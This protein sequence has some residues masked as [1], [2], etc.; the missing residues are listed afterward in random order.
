MV[1]SHTKRRQQ[2]QST[3]PRGERPDRIERCESEY[4]I[5]I[6]A[7]ARGATR[8]LHSVRCIREDFNPRSREG[9]DVERTEVVRA[10]TISIHAPARGATMTELL[11]SA[12]T[13]NFN[14]RSREG[15]DLRKIMDRSRS[16]IS[17]HA[18]ARGATIKMDNL[19]HDVVFQ[20]T[21]PRGERLKVWY[22]VDVDE[23][24]NPRS[25]EGSDSNFI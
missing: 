9:S 23:D 10:S 15:S 18:P 25:R 7:P 13:T 3:L 4:L 20:S 12:Q 8:R 22:G 11:C 16:R 17:I 19:Q 1:A 21:L 14:P 6:H 24:F 5:S 2:F